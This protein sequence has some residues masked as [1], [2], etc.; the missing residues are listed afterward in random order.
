MRLFGPPD[1]R[2]SR[3]PWLDAADDLDRD[4]AAAALGR[5]APVLAAKAA[6]EAFISEPV[7]DGGGAP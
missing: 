6:G 1:A 2:W 5:W 3:R 4:V 7:A